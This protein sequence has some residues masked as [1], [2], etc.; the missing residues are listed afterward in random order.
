MKE[1]K[2]LA[3]RSAEEDVESEWNE[4]TVS[5]VSKILFAVRENNELQAMEAAREQIEAG[6]PGILDDEV[7]EWRFFLVRL[8]TELALLISFGNAPTKYLEKRVEQEMIRIHACK[9]VE[10]CRNLTLQMVKEGCR[11]NQEAGGH[12]SVL[13]Q[14]IMEEVAT[15]LT[16]PLTLQYF[17]NLL[18]VNSSYL[19]NLFRQQTGITLTEYVTDKR[20]AHAATLLAFTRTPI[21][22]VAKQVGIPD[23]QYF[24][25]LF[26]RRMQMTP[27]QYREEMDRERLET[28][29]EKGLL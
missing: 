21:K 4:K 24:S 3:V 16:K 12:Y 15:D 20:I 28:L 22:T 10:D 6:I 27:T 23:V 19:S 2:D 14:R 13:V 7:E 8:L 25:R 11:L 29:V 9:S 18:N 5:P 26:K 1:E 17:A